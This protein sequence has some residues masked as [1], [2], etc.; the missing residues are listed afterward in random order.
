MQCHRVTQCRSSRGTRVPWSVG[1][2]LRTVSQKNTCISK[3]VALTTEILLGGEGKRIIT[4]DSAGTLI[5][6]DP[7]SATL[8]WKMNQHSSRFNLTEGITSLASN[9]TSSVALVGGSNGELRVVN[10]AKG[11]VVGVLEGHDQGQS[12]EAIEFVDWSG[13]AAGAQQIVATGATDGK[14]CIWDLVSMKLRS[15]VK[16]EVSLV[17]VPLLPLGCAETLAPS[18]LVWDFS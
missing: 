11:E 8:V 7:R 12:V 10:L 14:I 15:T 2:S 18:C 13:V 6:W 3:F 4:G 5:L 17:L 16:H 1:H 9:T